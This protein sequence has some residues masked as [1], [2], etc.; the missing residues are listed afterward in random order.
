ML[1]GISW[2]DWPTTLALAMPEWEIDYLLSGRVLVITT[3]P[4][5]MPLPTTLMLFKI[6]TSRPKS[7]EFGAMSTSHTQET[8]RDQLPS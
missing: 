1:L 7:K 3:S 8:S 2:L 6:S 5:P 4:L